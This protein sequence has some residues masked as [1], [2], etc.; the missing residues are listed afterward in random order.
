M[1]RLSFNYDDLWPEW[2]G[3]TDSVGVSASASVGGSGMAMGR[4]LLG[5]M[6]QNKTNTGA[7]NWV[8]RLIRV[9][10]DNITNIY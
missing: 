1:T 8:R 9:G 5:A 6:I 7:A 4:C 10:N 3:A 2:L